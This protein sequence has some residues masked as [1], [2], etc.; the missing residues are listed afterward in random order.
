M[1]SAQR[2]QTGLFWTPKGGNN[3]SEIWASCHTFSSVTENSETGEKET[4]TIIVDVG[5][6][7]NPKSFLGGIHDKVIP[8]LDDCLSVPGYKKPE[9][10]AEA[11]FLTHGHSDHMAGV[12]EYVRMGAELPKIYASDYTL[13]LLRKE[14]MEQ[15]IRGN[16]WPEMTSIKAGDVIKVGN[17]QVEPFPA[18]H[19]IP[20]CFS[21][22]ISNKEASIFHSG[23]T[24]ADETSFLEKGVNMKA[25]DKV[26]G[27]DLMTFDAT[28]T[29]RSGHAAYES[30]I[31]S[32]YRKLFSENKDKQIISVLPAA[33]VERLASVV[34]AAASVG[35]DVMFNGGPSMEK[36]VMAMNLA[37]Y[38]LQEMHPNI[39]VV[40]SRDS[41]PLDMK[42][43][44][45]IT[46]G[47]YGEESSPFVQ[48]LTGKVDGR[49][50]LNDD[51][52]II[53]PTARR[54]FERMDDILKNFAP[55][56]AT[57]I[58]ALDCNIYGSGHAQA[59]DFKKIAKR[60]NPKTVAP[61]HCSYENAKE[62]NKLAARCGYK[63]LNSYP[64][65][66]C[67]V[68][69]NKEGT[70]IVSEK[71]PAWFGINLDSS[72]FKLSD[73]GYST[74]KEV[75]RNV[76]KMMSSQKRQ[77]EAAKKINEWR[78]KQTLKRVVM[79]YKMREGHGK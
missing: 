26:G 50:V 3:A 38:N 59:D 35:K 43:S 6:N 39:R 77:Q 75:S 64:H 41:Q 5:Q 24:K 40:G 44:V 10:P 68:Q 36:N 9:K 31:F 17:M 29:N 76:E 22:K 55:K 58:S 16:L 15:G 60:V 57:V 8:A 13:K 2:S 61:I 51:A 79:A 1:S 25:Y 45:V 56:G 47:I 67:T 32:S 14:L 78:E 52:V 19:S 23:D 37:G 34:S 27:V 73:Y 62:F 65:N 7:E 11:I 63:T 49:F 30:E 66:G 18:S 48:K 28:A 54:P 74:G 20:G 12:V 42:K 69:V 70:K 46:T 53:T 71:E 21:F 72:V 4:T 33:H